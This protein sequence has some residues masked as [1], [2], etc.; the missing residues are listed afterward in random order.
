MTREDSLALLR[1]FCRAH[2]PSGHEAEIDPLILAEFEGRGYE[3]VTD[4]AGNLYVVRPGRG[5]GRII[6]CAHKDEIGVIVKRVDFDGKLQIRPVGGSHP[7]VWG[8]GPMDILGDDAIVP[9]V[10]SFGARHT[11]SETPGHAARSQALTWDM[12]WIETMQSPD[13]LDEAGVHIGSKAVVAR[14]RKDPIE[15]GNYIAGYGLDDKAA[16]VV[17]FEVLDQLED[18]VA[19]RELVFAITKEEET[20]AIGAAWLARALPADI[21]LA[22]EIAP[23]ADEYHTVCDERPVVLMQDASNLYDERIAR[24]LATAATNLNLGIQHACLSGFGSDASI[25]GKYGLTARPA[26]VGFAT[27][28]THGYEIAHAAS[29]LN[30]ARLIAEWIRQFG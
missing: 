22:I 13:A 5:E 6:I 11:S 23:V 3:P 29:F 14:H 12:V 26:C 8:E 9:G 28:N 17:L 27:E 16:M 10:L 19:E 25:T 21:M 4:A 18:F 15:M 20:G 1:L 2:S 7:W 24:E 30:C